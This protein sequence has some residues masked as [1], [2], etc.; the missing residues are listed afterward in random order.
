MEGPKRAGQSDR[1]MESRGGG[2]KGKRARRS[3]RG[4]GHQHAHV[5]VDLA[6]N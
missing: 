6:S 3:F 5:V 4:N 2:R 1:T